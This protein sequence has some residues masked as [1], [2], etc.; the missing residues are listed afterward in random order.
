MLMKTLPLLTRAGFLAATLCLVTSPALRAE[1]SSEQKPYAEKQL[2]VE[3]KAFDK[4]GDGK[5]S[6]EEAAAYKEARK[7][8]HKARLEKY[9]TDKDGKLSEEEKAAFKADQKKEK[10]EKKK[11]P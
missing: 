9:D 7:A 4:D 6:E 10:P 5:L 3:K 2:S 11:Q 8:E 1:G